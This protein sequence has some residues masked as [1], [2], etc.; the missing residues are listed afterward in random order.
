MSQFKAFHRTI[1]TTL[2]ASTLL[3][4]LASSA[5][6]KSQESQNIKAATAEQIIDKA[7]KK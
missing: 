1:F 4:P 7:T 5:I 6:A 3:L 2:V